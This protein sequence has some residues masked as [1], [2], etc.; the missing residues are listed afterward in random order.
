MNYSV[1]ICNMAICNTL[2]Y[3]ICSLRL[4]SGPSWY[5]KIYTCTGYNID[6]GLY[7]Q[8]AYMDI[9]IC[10]LQIE[11]P[12]DNSIEQQARDLSKGM[13]SCYILILKHTRRTLATL[14]TYMPIY[15]RCH[16]RLRAG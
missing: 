16:S 11:E 10:K 7:I 2:Y 1:I 6:T 8:C 9:H 14:N 4:T 15:F 13:H 3:L 5:T 12:G